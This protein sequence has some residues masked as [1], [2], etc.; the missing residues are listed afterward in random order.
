MQK[1]FT[2]KNI[3]NMRFER[4]QH[5]ISQQQASQRPANYCQSKHDP[6]LGPFYVALY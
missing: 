6:H 1:K 5:R 2:A 4:L 3:E